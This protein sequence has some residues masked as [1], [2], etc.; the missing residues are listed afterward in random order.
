L[1]DSSVVFQSLLP[2]ISEKCVFFLDGH[3][4]GGDTGHSEKDCPLE[5]EV[6]HISLLFRP[7]AILI[8]DDFRLFGLDRTPGEQGEDW[9]QINKAKLLRL[10]E[11]R[12][13]KVYHLP[14]DLAADDRLVVHVA[15]LH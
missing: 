13:E 5:E 11:G 2:T 9:T 4:S 10:L 8:I 1:G 3:W 6:A 15:A 12:I 7:A 14:S